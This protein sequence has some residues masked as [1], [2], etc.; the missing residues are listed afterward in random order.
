M[1]SAPGWPA[2]RRRSRLA[3]RG[4]RVDALRGGTAG[5]RALPLLSRR[6]ARHDDRQRQSSGAVGQRGGRSLPARDR[7][8]RTLDRARRGRNSHFVDFAIGRALDAAPERRRC[9][10]VDLRCRTRR[11][12]GTRLRDYLALLALL[13]RHPGRRIDEVIRCDGV[14]WEKFLRPVLLAALN[15]APE[16]ASAD[17][18]GAIVRETLAKGGRHIRPLH[19]A[20]PSL[21]AA[22][23]DP[24]LD[25][26]RRARRG[27]PRSAARCAPSRSTDGRAVGAGLRRRRGDA[28][29]ARRSR[30]PRGAALGRRR[31][32]CR[33]STRPMTFHAIVNAHFRI[34]P[35]PAGAPPCSA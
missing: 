33:A 6:P 7:R 35:P 8:G 3:G 34:V 19:R 10:L 31:S 22:F 28:V 21:A 15:T 9:A 1:S 5:R 27:H 32:C 18:A 17:L 26:L 11:V 24:A 29:A 30:D 16:E 20:S 12:P 2:C 14:L 25:R 4:V 13:R 23:V